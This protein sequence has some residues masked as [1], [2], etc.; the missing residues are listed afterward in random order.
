MNE[1]SR[2]APVDEGTAYLGMAA[3]CRR[4]AAAGINP[5][6]HKVNHR[7]WIALARRARLDGRRV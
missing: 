2:R 5:A 6:D 4:L 1:L 3:R 7:L